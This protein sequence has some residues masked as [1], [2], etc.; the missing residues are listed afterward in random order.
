MSSTQQPK[1]PK[2]LS[3]AL[4]EC[5]AYAKRGHKLAD[6]AVSLLGR[7]VNKVSQKLQG[8]IDNLQKSNFNDNATSR[9]LVSQLSSIRSNF[10]I[11]PQK[12]VD[13]IKALSEASFSITL[14]GRTMAGKSTLMEILTHGKGESIGKGAQRTTRDVRTYTYKDLKIT[15]VPGIAAFDGEDDENIAFEAAKKCDLILFLITDDA[16]QACEAECLNRILELGKPVICLINIKADVNSAANIKMFK[17]DVQKKFDNT[18]LEAIKQQFFAFGNQYGQDWHAIRFAYVHLKSAFLSQQA[19]SK[20]D[21]SEFYGLS[22]FSYVDNLIVSE[23][24]KNCIFYKIKSF[25]DI[26]IV[27]VVDALETLFSQSAKN[28]EQGSVLVGKKRKL[29]KWTDDFETDS[30]NRIKT[31]L[32]SI[33]SELKREIASFAEVN[34][35]NS[36]ASSKWGE[37]LKKHRVEERASNLLKQLGEECE[38]ELR[39]ISRE[40]NAEIKFS[41]TV[42]SDD[43]I[44]MQILVNSKRIWN[45]TTTLLSSGLMIASLLNVWNPIGWIGLGIGL[46]VSLLGWLGSFLFSDREKKIRDARRELEKKLSDHIDKMVTEL[47]KKLLDVLSYELLR[48]QLYPMSRTIDGVIH[49]VFTLSQTQHEFAISLNNKLREMN[50]AVIKEALAY[51]GYEGLEWHISSVARIP[52]YAVMLVFEYGKV[53]PNDAAKALSNL[54]KEKVWY[55]I[56]NDNI[57]S[58]LLQALWRKADRGSVDVQSITIQDIDGAPRIAHIPFLDAVDANTKNRIRMAQQITELLIM[59]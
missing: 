54:L 36:S 4:L 28:S 22:R 13:D 32:T 58:M 46:G 35:D 27:P 21:S 34:Y 17:R 3:E 43:L 26:V 23:V 7:V 9:S 10:G 57:K 42:F 29:E 5:K 49:S 2:D 12:L 50:G 16:P 25:L 24:R 52:G 53:F 15:D 47:R 19:E 18:R 1:S 48:K 51:L 8:E 45:W 30:I 11:L 33:S 14:F 40:I 59:K 41:H 55:I 56:K 44:N 38:A 6:D 39:E 31:L 20:E 37:I